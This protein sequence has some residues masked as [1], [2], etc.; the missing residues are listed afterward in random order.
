MQKR[1]KERGTL[2][3]EVSCKDK[4]VK[5]LFNVLKGNGCLLC[6]ILDNYLLIKMCYSYLQLC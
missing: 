6:Y 1:S 3:T 2:K 5:T 4:S